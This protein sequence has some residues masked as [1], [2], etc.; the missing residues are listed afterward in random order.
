MTTGKT[1]VFGIL[2][3]EILTATYCR[4]RENMAEAALSPKISLVASPRLRW[5]RKRVQLGRVAKAVKL[6]ILTKQDS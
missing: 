2:I 4:L 5:W 6:A 3:R 1:E